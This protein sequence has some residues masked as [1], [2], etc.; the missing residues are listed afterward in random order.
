MSPLPQGQSVTIQAH[1]LGLPFPCS[2]GKG[3]V[4]RPQPGEGS[5]GPG[6][7]QVQ[8][9]KVWPGVA[10]KQASEGFKGLYC[11]RLFLG[12]CDFHGQRSQRSRK[13]GGSRESKGLAKQEAE[14][15]VWAGLAF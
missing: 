14:G 9:R 3:G 2:A 6:T 5:L 10:H 13:D 8:S 11:S 15:G 12:G 4:H 1:Y 7:E